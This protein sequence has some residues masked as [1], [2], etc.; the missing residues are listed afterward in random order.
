MRMVIPVSC[1]RMPPHLESPDVV[2]QIH[3][4]RQL[5]L[6]ELDEVAVDRGAIEAAVGQRLGNIGVGGWTRQGEQMLEHR[7]AGSGTT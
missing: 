1:L 3:P 4:R 2:A 5:R 7:H 6:G